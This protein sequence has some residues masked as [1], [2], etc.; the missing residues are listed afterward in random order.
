MWLLQGQQIVVYTETTLP[1]F[2]AIIR[3]IWIPLLFIDYRGVH[4][5]PSPSE[6]LLEMHTNFSLDIWANYSM[7]YSRR[8]KSKLWFFIK[9][10][11]IMS[12]KITKE[13]WTIFS[14]K[15]PR[16]VKFIHCDY[17]SENCRGIKFLNCPYV[18]ILAGY[19]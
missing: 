11:T 6:S 9:L 14:T 18:K 13:I 2:H 10:I 7:R 1:C 16:H 15:R 8:V 3:G 4:V 17:L 19:L 5:V 12:T